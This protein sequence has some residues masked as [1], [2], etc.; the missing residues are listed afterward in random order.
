[1]DEN[2]EANIPVDEWESLARLANILQV[3]N[4]VMNVTEATNTDI[5]KELQKQ[6][7]EY[8]GALVAD[9]REIK[10]KQALMDEKLDKIME[11]LNV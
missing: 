8:L 11:K 10:E 4:F 7:N 6:D 1:M 9:V 2:N 3:A 5:L